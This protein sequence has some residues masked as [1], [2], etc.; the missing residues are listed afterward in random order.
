MS[1]KNWYWDIPFPIKKIENILS[2]EDDPR[3]PALA[4]TLIARVRD[5]RQV[6]SLITPVAFCRHF[7]AIVKEITSDAWTRQRA[8]FW[9]VTYLRLSKELR[10]KGEKIRKP[11]QIELD[12][13]DKDLIN[14]VK[15]CRKNAWMSQKELAQWM[16]VSQQYISGIEKGRDRIAIPF[17]KKLAQITGQKIDLVVEKTTASR[18]QLLKS[19]CKAKEDIKAGRTKSLKDVFGR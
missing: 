8:A 19:V 11:A 17:L 9:K 2:R 15:E 12:N 16:G 4:G 3:F 1:A 7:R 13:F 6:F 18:R 5:P 14:K 10:K